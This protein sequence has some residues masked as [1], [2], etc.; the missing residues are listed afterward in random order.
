MLTDPRKAA[1]RL[2]VWTGEC[3][4][5]L[6]LWQEWLILATRLVLFVVTPADLTDR[7]V[8]GAGLARVKGQEYWGHSRAFCTN[9][10][11]QYSGI[12]FRVS[13]PLVGVCPWL[14]NYTINSFAH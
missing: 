10:E 5:E 12:D 4:C 11:K 3:P 8:R 1:D 14:V 13:R 2:G 7:G 6:E 9:N